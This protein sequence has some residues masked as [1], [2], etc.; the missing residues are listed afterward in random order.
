MKAPKRIVTAL[1]AA[2]MVAASVA[3]PALASSHREAPVVAGDPQ[4]DGTDTFAFVSPDNPDSVTLVANY[5]PF[6]DPPG[7]PNFYPFANDA[8]YNINVDTDGDAVPNLTYRF[9]FSGGFQDKTTFLYNTG[10]VNNLDD[11]TLNF[12][13]NYKV[14]QLGP[15]GKVLSTVVESG[16][17]APSNVGVAS[18][19]NYGALRQQSLDSGAGSDGTKT[20]AGQADDP[21]F[22]DLR[23]FDLLYGGDLSETGNPVLTGKNVNSIS[24]QIP[25]SVLGANGLDASGVVGVWTTSERQSMLAINADGTRAASGDWVQ[26]SRLGN[27]LVNEVVSSVELKDAFNALKP[28]KDGSV[29][30]LVDRVTDPEVPKLIEKIYGIPAPATPRDDLVSVFLT[31]VKGLN[32]P[33]KVTPSE[34]MRLNTNTPVTA[35]PNR[36]GVLAGDAGGFPNGRRLTDDVVDIELQTLEGAIQADG[37]IKLVD[38]LAA[39]DGVNENDVPFESSFPYVALPNPGSNTGPGGLGGSATGSSASGSGAAAPSGG[40]ATGFGGTANQAT[41]ANSGSSNLPIVPIAILGAGAAVTAF[42]FTRSRR[43]AKA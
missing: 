4:I 18:M 12:K 15:D 25:K 16:K 34:M 31:G 28:E 36:L 17:V 41:P 38:A 42:G 30:G 43:T 11:A 21:F 22:L 19:P 32:Q 26:T 39:G 37:S 14:E 35:E 5:I 27:P 8:R 1:G 23:V 3:T 2:T 24:V 20:F 7:G 9:T 29:Q 13:Q 40:V 33:T 10:P 6:Q